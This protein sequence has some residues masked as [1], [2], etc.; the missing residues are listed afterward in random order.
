MAK[1][2]LRIRLVS[3][4]HRLLDDSAQRIAEAA[5]R[6]GAQVSGPVPLPTEREVFTVIR[7]PHKHKDSREH[8]ER[9]THKR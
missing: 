2:V 9:N 7:S 3:Y 8:F 5:K 4:D 1:Q 6:S